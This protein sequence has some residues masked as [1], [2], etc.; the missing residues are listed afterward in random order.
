MKKYLININ[1]LNEIEEYKKIGITNF[2][3]AIPDF[4]IGYNT[5]PIKD[6]PND[7]YIFINRLLD[8]NDVIKLKEKKEELMRFKG[9]IFEDIS[10]Y[11]IFKD[12]SLELIWNQAHFATN[13]SSINFWLD[14]VSSAI[15][16][17]EITK[18][19]IE[20]IVKHANKP[21]II[22]IF[23]RNNI[24]YSRRTLLSN[25]NKYNNLEKYNNMN[26]KTNN[27]DFYAIEDKHGTLLF[28]N[29]YFNY[30]NKLN[31]DDDKIKFYMILNLDFSVS[32][33]SEIING[34]SIGNDG[35]LNKKTVYKLADYGD[36]KG[37]RD[38]GK[39]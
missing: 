27:N 23:G 21:I 24:M 4:S 19:E 16:S 31:L 6:I 39:N 37:D 18:E 8:T 5:I 26:L 1:Q 36:K 9:I 15:I 32:K 28:N 22:N 17:N 2:L 33:I 14:H 10:V 25:F 13:A 12:T 20:Y 38:N 29:D 34:L 7:G 35:F 30:I 11:Q 3:F